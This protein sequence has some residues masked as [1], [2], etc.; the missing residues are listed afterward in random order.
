[1]AM[2]T[3]L[4][5][6]SRRTDGG[7]QRLGLE[8]GYRAVNDLS[9][10]SKQSVPLSAHEQDNYKNRRTDNHIGRDCR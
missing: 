5:T 9:Q 4:W 8:Q 3:P 2:I 6:G 10:S 7:K 1:M